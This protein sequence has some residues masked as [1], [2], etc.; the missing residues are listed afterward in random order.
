MRAKKGSFRPKDT[1]VVGVLEGVEDLSINDEIFGGFNGESCRKD[2]INT[3][4]EEIRYLCED[5]KRNLKILVRNRICLA[6][7]DRNE[8]ND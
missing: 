5:W 3:R 4:R 1:S 2:E 7:S 8:E 6:R